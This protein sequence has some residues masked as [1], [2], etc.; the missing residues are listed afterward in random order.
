MEFTKIKKKTATLH[1]MVK[2]TIN[3]EKISDRMGLNTGKP[4]FDKGSMF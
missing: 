2:M 3:T 1:C 4:D